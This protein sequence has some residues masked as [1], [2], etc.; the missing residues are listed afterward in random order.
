MLY[1]SLVVSGILVA[2]VWLAAR[3]AKYP[4]ATTLGW[5]GAA[6]IFP[7]F[8]MMWLPA[9]LLQAA[10]LFGV[11]LLAQGVHRGRQVM[12][13][14]A[15]VSLLIAYGVVGWNEYDRYRTEERQLDELRAAGDAERLAVLERA[16]DQEL[17]LI[18]I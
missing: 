3:G 14:A 13:P 7:M 4:V 1:L 8:L 15:V 11:V 16:I 5:A 2:G 18:H 6:C 9:V 10:I 12:R 17:S